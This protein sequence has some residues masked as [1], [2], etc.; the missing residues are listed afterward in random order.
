[1][2]R[3]LGWMGWCWIITNRLTLYRV[4]LCC[5]LVGC[6]TKQ[7]RIEP[8]TIES[9]IIQ[10]I[11]ALLVGESRYLSVDDIRYRKILRECDKLIQVD[12][13]QG[14]IARA[15]A[16]SIVGDMQMGESDLANALKL[17]PGLADDVKFV[18]AHFLL[19][20]GAHSSALALFK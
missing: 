11:N 13:A 1:M 2:Q 20:M 18:W 3:C 9:N 6:Y 4:T 12:P 17:A 10:S 16:R 5:V 8:A 7:M 14:Y 19:N 15:M